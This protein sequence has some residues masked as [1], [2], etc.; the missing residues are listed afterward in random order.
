MIRQYDALIIQCIPHSI[1]LRFFIH[2]VIQCICGKVC[3]RM[4]QQPVFFT[5]NPPQKITY[6]VSEFSCFPHDSSLCAKLS[7]LLDGFIFI[8]TCTNR[9]LVSILS[10]HSYEESQ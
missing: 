4:K 9:R 6:L 7:Q 2:F 3:P 10:P 1:C 8:F 5:L